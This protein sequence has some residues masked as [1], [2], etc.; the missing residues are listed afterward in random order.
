MYVCMHTYIYIYMVCVCARSHGRSWPS[1]DPAPGGGYNEAGFEWGFGPE[2]NA[3]TNAEGLNYSCSL[4]AD[5]VIDWRD[6]GVVY[7]YY[8][9]TVAGV[10]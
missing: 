1:V 2:A 3:E 9:P 5:Q 7:A 10:V 4:W 8:R 6:C